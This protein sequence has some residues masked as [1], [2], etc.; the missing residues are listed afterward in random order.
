MRVAG[1]RKPKYSA[2]NST[3]PS[4]T[5]IGWSSP[6]TG[7]CHSLMMLSVYDMSATW[8]GKSSPSMPFG[9]NTP[10]VTVS[11]R[12]GAHAFAVRTG[13]SAVRT[14]SSASAMA[15]MMPSRKLACMLAQTSMAATSQRL[16]RLPRSRARTM[17]ATQITIRGQAIVWG[18]ASRCWI[19]VRKASTVP[20]NAC[21]GSI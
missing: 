15:S 19:S 14:A 20:V 5:T 17:P 18:R 2:P 6:I 12:N 21:S 11:A 9:V 3:T 10:A 4:H 7:G 13:W 16:G 8:S 1:K